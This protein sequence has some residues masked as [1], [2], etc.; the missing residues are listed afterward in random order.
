MSVELKHLYLYSALWFIQFF[1]IYYLIEPI[2]QFYH[3]VI[4][5][6]IKMKKER[7]KWFKKFAQDH[8]VIK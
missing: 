5:P 7:L 6:I 4:I 1:Q 3:Q 8:T 2:K